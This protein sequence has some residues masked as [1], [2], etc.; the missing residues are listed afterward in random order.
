MSGSQTPL[1]FTRG[2]TQGRDVIR[3]AG[4]RPFAYAGALADDSPIVYAGLDTGACS[5]SHLALVP[6]T[7]RVADATGLGDGT[8][9]PEA[10]EHPRTRVPPPGPAVVAARSLVLTATLGD[11]APVVEAGRGA[12]AGT[13][14]NRTMVRAASTALVA[15][16]L[17]DGSLVQYAGLLPD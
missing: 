11:S 10:G 3:V 12:D 2:P 6:T 4:A 15:G 14:T 17:P 1:P 9:V 7:G 8:S 13:L 5:F 16:A